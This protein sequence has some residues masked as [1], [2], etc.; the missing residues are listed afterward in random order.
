MHTFF[1]GWRRK[2]GVVTLVMAVVVFGAW[3]RSLMVQDT[4]FLGSSFINVSGGMIAQQAWVT[5][6]VYPVDIP[7]I[8]SSDPHAV[9]VVIGDVGPEMVIGN[10]Y[11]RLETMW[12]IPYWSLV[13]PLTLLS[14]YFIL[15]KP[16]TRTKKQ[17]NA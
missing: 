11:L 9:L 3:M 7:K 4:F 14:A 2:V 16:R 1:H 8:A 5:D 17:P 10:P 6:Q 12:A 13:L 15:W